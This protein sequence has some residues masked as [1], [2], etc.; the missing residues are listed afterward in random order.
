[1]VTVKTV[2]KTENLLCLSKKKMK[3]VLLLQVKPTSLQLKPGINARENP[4]L[5][6]FI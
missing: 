3:I 6:F 4:I 2:G 1:M 5:K